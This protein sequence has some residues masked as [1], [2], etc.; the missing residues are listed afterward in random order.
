MQ[1]L[2]GVISALDWINT[3]ILSL[4]KLLTTVLVGII[5][6]NVFVGVFW[7]YVSE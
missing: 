1:F 2:A 5:A 3:K 7:R 4:C 6:L